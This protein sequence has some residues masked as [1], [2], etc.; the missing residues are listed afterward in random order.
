MAFVEV[1]SEM[2]KTEEETVSILCVTDNDALS[3]IELLGLSKHQYLEY[4]LE[5]LSQEVG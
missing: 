4:Y 5:E 2:G 1:A 3:A